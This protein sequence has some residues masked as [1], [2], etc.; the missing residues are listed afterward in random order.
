MNPLLAE[1]TDQQARLLDVVYRGCELSGGWPIFQYVEEV[2]YR[3][4]DALDAQTVL[5]ECP[6]IRFSAGQGRYGWVSAQAPSLQAVGPEHRLSLTVAGMTRL[7]R[8]HHDVDLFLDV[9]GY[10]VERGRSFTPSPTTVQAV[11]VKSAEL[12]RDLGPPRG[13]RFLDSAAL[14]RIGELLRS[15][16]STWNCQ[17]KAADEPAMWTASLSPFIRRYAGVQTA[18]EYVDRLVEL[19]AP[20]SPASEPLHPS[21]LSLPEAID[22]LNAVWRL[23]AGK[24]LFTI[25]RAEAAAKLALDCVN[26]DELEARLSALCGILSH[27]QLPDSEDNGSL[28]Q[29]KKYLKE[30]LPAG[31]TDRA[32][33]AVDDLRAFVDL[34]VWRQHPGADQRGKQGMQRLE[35]EL[36]TSDW[37][38]AWRH[39]QARAVAALSALREE[40]ETLG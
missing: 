20:P 16:P 39:L 34:R 2:L 36:P 38:G 9:L 3:D 5:L 18:D 10:L 30:S 1:P 33:E 29:F 8:A 21:S 25:A 24:P 26:A 37:E 11:E 14:V 4:H 19:I 6:Y 12:Q 13:Q 17:I 15:E 32:E 22:Y 23:H 40:V 28:N 35:V 31:A 27:L 7:D